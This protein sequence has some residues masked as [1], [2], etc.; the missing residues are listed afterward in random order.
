MAEIRAPF[1]WFGG[2]SRIAPLV[3]SRFGNVPNYV[4][5]FAGSL[6]VLLM[7]PHTAQTETVNDRDAYLVNF[8]RAVAAAPDEVAAFADW[9][10]SEIDLHARH[11]WIL[12]QRDL[13]SRLRADP[14][15]FDP[16]L[17]GWWV[18]GL[19][20]WIGDGWCRDE[21]RQM[22]MVGR[23]IHSAARLPHLSH[24]SK[25]VHSEAR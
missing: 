1:P 4:E 9:P 19:S 16:K 7:R 20:A 10:V 14:E 25:G 17:A 22:P 24:G 3:W 15:F 11:S 23:G 5:P 6:A 2:K 21:A 13:V 18:W 8:W 12:A